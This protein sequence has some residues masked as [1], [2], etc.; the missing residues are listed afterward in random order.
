MASSFGFAAPLIAHIASTV[1]QAPPQRLGRAG[2]ERRNP[3]C[4][5]RTPA[6]PESFFGG[7]RHSRTVGG[8]SRMRRSTSAR[9]AVR[10]VRHSRSA[11]S[12]GSSRGNRTPLGGRRR[13]PP[14][15]ATCGSSNA[16]DLRSTDAV[17]GAH[18]TSGRTRVNPQRYKANP[19]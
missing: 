17:L 10:Q 15:Y 18:S 1:P 7:L 5:A 4:R 2:P 19:A 13:L 11:R 8:W 12:G 14:R 3:K 16:L 6:S 9:S